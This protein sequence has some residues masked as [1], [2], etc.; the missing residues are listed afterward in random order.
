MK[1]VLSCFKCGSTDFENTIQRCYEIE[2]NS[3][4]LQEDAETAEVICTR[5]GLKDYV[6]N[7]VIVF[8]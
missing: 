7:L 8:E 2:D 1:L 4:L 3:Y 6:K 5:C